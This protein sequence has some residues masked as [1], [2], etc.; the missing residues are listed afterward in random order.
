MVYMNIRLMSC[1]LPLAVFVLCFKY[2]VIDFWLVE[3]L[4]MYN[5]QVLKALI[6]VGVEIFSCTLC[7]LTVVS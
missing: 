7:M 4:I 2:D 1:P 5:I 6:C 3:I